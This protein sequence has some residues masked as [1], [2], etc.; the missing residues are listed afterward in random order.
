VPV[1][2]ND[3][4]FGVLNLSNKKDGTLF[5]QADLDRAILLAQFIAMSQER[6][7]IGRKAQAWAS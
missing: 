5:G 7:Q 1:V 2:H 6:M 4:L 3:V